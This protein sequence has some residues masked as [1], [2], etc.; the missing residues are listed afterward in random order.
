MSLRQ[1]RAISTNAT[2]SKKICKITL[3]RTLPFNR[4][5]NGDR[6]RFQLDLET[7]CLNA[8]LNCFFCSPYEVSICTPFAVLASEHPRHDLMVSDNGRLEPYVTPKLCRY[9]CLQNSYLLFIFCPINA[10]GRAGPKGCPSAET[11]SACFV[12]CRF[13]CTCNCTY[14]CR[15]ISLGA[16]QG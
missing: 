9:Q 12:V 11:Q 16:L 15:M 2:Q 1:L 10:L 7:R 13:S 5:F 3:V 8:F 6:Y 14:S 4:R